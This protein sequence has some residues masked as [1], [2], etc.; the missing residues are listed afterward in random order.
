[1][2]YH[3]GLLPGSHPTPFLI[4]PS[5]PPTVVHLASVSSQENATQANPKEVIPHQ[6][7]PV[8]RCFTVI[9]GVSCVARVVKTALKRKNRVRETCKSANQDGVVLVYG[10]IN[11][12]GNP[13]IGSHIYN[14]PIFT[15]DDS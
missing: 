12:T 3:V 6:K 9:T 13:D 2:L 15:K 5:I 1:M 14:Q 8:L 11:R 10:H 4:P 7:F